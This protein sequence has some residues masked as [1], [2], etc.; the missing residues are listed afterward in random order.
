MLYDHLLAYAECETPQELIERFRSLFI[1][2][3]GYPSRKVVATLDEILDS[4]DID[5]YFHYILNRCCHILVNRWQSRP[6]LQDAVT[7]F[8]ETL[9]QGPTKQVTEYSRSRQIRKLREIVTEFT[10]TEQYLTLKRLACLVDAGCER[11]N[12]TDLPLGTLIQRYPYLYRHCL[13]SDG[14][15]QE[16]QQHIRRIQVKAQKKFEV[17]LS[18]Y[19]TY[20][21]R[22]A[23]L[24]KQDFLT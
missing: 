20:R 24:E 11:S 15:P 5:Q 14:S 7:A 16:H 23:R 13:V 9:E 18:Q 22:R 2:G 8:V 6:Q 19:V 10:E 3:V 12:S 21:V 4:N 17:N 1:D